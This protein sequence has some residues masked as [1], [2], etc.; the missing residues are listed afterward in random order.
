MRTLSQ[1]RVPAKLEHLERLLE[2]VSSSARHAGIADSR[3]REIEVAAEEALVNVF[4]YAYSGD[5][6]DVEVT[7]KVT[8]KEEF[9]VEIADSGRPFDPTTREEP[10]TAAD[11]AHRKVGGLGILLTKKLMNDMKYRRESEKNVLSL[12]VLKESG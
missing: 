7:C 10:D 8:G 5:Q 2:V 4:H 11:I 12:V 6:G 1:V 9:I 3:I